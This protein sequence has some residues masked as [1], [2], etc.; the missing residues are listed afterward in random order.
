VGGRRYGRNQRGSCSPASKVARSSD[1]IPAE[2]ALFGDAQTGG[3]LRNHVGLHA[4]EAQTM[5]RGGEG[6][7]QKRPHTLRC[8]V[9]AGVTRADLPAGIGA[10]EDAACEVVEVEHAGEVVA[11]QEKRAEAENASIVEAAPRS[12]EL[13]REELVEGDTVGRARRPGAEVFAGVLVIRD[14]RRAIIFLQWAQQKA[15]CA[16]RS[17][18]DG[19]IHGHTPPEGGRLSVSGT[20]CSV[21]RMLSRPRPKRSSAIE[22]LPSTV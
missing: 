14:E 13:L 10:L 3:V 12:L 6:N 19:M 16:E 11:I 7:V 15:L 18:R 1:R 22:G 2:A 17:E 5:G 4:V 21:R 9:F 8:E 20:T